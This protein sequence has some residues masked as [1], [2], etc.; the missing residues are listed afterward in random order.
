VD[1]AGGVVGIVTG[2]DVMRAIQ[3]RALGEAWEGRRAA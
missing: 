3:V 2:A 1:R